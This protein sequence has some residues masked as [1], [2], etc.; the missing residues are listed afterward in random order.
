MAKVGDWERL[1]Y[2]ERELVDA[3]LDFANPWRFPHPRRR[4]R[5]TTR[6]R[7]RK[8]RVDRSR[9]EGDRAISRAHAWVCQALQGLAKSRPDS[10]KPLRTPRIEP[11]RLADV[12]LVAIPRIEG[13]RVQ[14]TS[15]AIV[16]AS[17]SGL[18]AYA[19][20]LIAAGRYRVGICK[21]EE[22]QRF[23]IPP[24][25]RGRYEEYCCQRHQDIAQGK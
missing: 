17:V 4:V 11:L 20:A 15:E 13:S 16:V 2:S 24:S 9:P 10:V 19:V 14:R 8:L 6:A 12:R 22:C 25:S 7:Y 1:S 5:T 21:L 23:F 18:C 3:V